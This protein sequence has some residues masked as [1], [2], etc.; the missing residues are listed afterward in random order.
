M[1]LMEDTFEILLS[2]ETL[3]NT[4]VVIP[5]MTNHFL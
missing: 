5:N 1:L 4:Y 2:D 3:G